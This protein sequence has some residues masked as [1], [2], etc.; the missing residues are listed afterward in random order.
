VQATAT[1][2]EQDWQEAGQEAD[3]GEDQ[4]GKPDGCPARSEDAAVVGAADRDS[5]QARAWRLTGG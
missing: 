4:S 5:H 2:V 1:L 3:R